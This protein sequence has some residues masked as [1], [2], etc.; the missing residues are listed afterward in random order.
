MI[1]KRIYLETENRDPE[2]YLGIDGSDIPFEYF[3]GV[4][5]EH[6][7]VFSDEIHGVEFVVNTDRNCVNIFKMDKNLYVL[8]EDLE[9]DEWVKIMTF[10]EP[11]E[12][13]YSTYSDLIGFDTYMLSQ[14]QLYEKFYSQGKQG[15][16]KFSE[17]CYDE[18][19][20]YYMKF[21]STFDTRKQKDSTL[22]SEV[23]RHVQYVR[24]AHMGSLQPILQINT[25]K[26]LWDKL[27]KEI[28]E[29]N[30]SYE[31]IADL[32]FYKI[33]L[34]EDQQGEI[35]GISGGNLN[36]STIYFKEEKTNYFYITKS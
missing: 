15:F 14:K 29:K 7:L 23:I 9:N 20:I 4:Y 36:G 33:N 25:K 17:K 12:Q 10:F 6:G 21:K 22:L 11:N 27:I 5:F 19:K 26:H 28:K 1:P 13:V 16:L 32:I 18:E 2:I 30:S 35:I 8:K 3:K 31:R 34:I 24:L